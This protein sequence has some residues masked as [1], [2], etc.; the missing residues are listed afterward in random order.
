MRSRRTISKKYRR[1]REDPTDCFRDVWGNSIPKACTEV[2]RVS[3]QKGRFCAHNTRIEGN[4]EIASR[5]WLVDHRRDHLDS[6]AD[7]F[8]G[9]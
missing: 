2:R 8:L 3:S 5:P 9:M 6:H 4:S 7:L 1:F